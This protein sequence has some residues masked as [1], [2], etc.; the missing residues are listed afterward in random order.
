MTALRRPAPAQDACRIARLMRSAGEMM[1]PERLAA[2][3]PSRVSASRALLSHAIR[4]RWQILCKRF[5]IDEKGNGVA[6]YRIDIGS[7]RFSFP[8][9]L[10]SPRPMVAPVGSS[11]G[12]GT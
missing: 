2:I 6:E 5:E 8:V 9:F 10:L 11:A 1:A 7:W 12:P 3:Q 4:G